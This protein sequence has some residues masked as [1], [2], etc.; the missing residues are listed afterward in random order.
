MTEAGAREVIR[1]MTVP[2]AAEMVEAR[3]MGGPIR[4]MYARTREA[5]QPLA[6]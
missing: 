5:V 6:S 4:D 3:R 2:A 1:N